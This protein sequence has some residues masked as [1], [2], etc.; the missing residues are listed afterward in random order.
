MTTPD[1]AG[2]MRVDDRR[3]AAHFERL[4]AKHGVSYRAFDW[5]SRRSQEKRFEI[6]SAV[7]SMNGASLLDIGCG[8]GGL[9]GWLK[10]R[11][12]RPRYTGVDITSGMIAAAERRHPDARFLCGNVLTLPAA[13]LGRHDFVVASGIFYLRKTR[14]ERFMQETVAKMYRL[15]RVGAAF[16]SLSAWAASKEG[17][18]FYADPARALSF[19]RTLTKRVVLRHDYHPA[20]FTIYLYREDCPA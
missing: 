8:A 2:R 10:R 4:L 11:G 3:V 18:E 13:E 1:A 16:N 7:G 12:A 19:C 14:P 15:C 20:D 5:G 6:L 9:Y 17:G